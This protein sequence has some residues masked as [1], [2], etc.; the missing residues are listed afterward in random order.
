LP[1]TKAIDCPDGLARCEAGVVSRSLLATIPLP[2]SGPPGGC[3]CPWERIA[4]CDQGC[5]AD[6]LEL[7]I[8]RSQARTQLCAPPA[9]A[10]PFARATLPTRASV[11]CQEGQRFACTAG[12]MVECASS[13]VIGL[14]IHGCYAEGASIDDDG[15]TREATFAL[16]CSR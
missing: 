14:C 12:L 1:P 3:V 6:G 9:G 5:A 4:D 15:A 2:C 10:G 13:T 7:V 8:D 11:P 16:L